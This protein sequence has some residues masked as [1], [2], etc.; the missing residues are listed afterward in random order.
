V[1]ADDLDNDETFKQVKQKMGITYSDTITI[2]P[3]IFKDNY[4][5]KVRATQ[6]SKTE[7]YLIFSLEILLKL[8]NAPCCLNRIKKNRMYSCFRSSPRSD[9]ADGNFPRE[10]FC[11]MN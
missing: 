7:N 11:I 5:E 3:D 4:D 10:K 2:S 1:N 6:I 9:P 8:L